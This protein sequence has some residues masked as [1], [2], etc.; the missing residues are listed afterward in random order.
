MNKIINFFEEMSIRDKIITLVVILILLIIV[1]TQYEKYK[2]NVNNIYTSKLDYKSLTSESLLENYSENYSNRDV[3]YTINQIIEN[4]NNEYDKKKNNYKMYYETVDYNY[5][6]KISKKTF[7]NKLY[8]LFEKVNNSDGEY[9]IRMYCENIISNTFVV[10]V[11]VDDTII[12]YIGIIFNT[13]NS[14]YSI[15]YVETL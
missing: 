10:Q 8:S 3:Y 2:E 12:G 7:S 5:S 11:Y 14:T 1:T 13:D 9:G 6:K 15:F 4:M